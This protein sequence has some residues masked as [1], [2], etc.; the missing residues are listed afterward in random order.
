MDKLL[1]KIADVYNNYRFK[2]NKIN[3]GNYSDKDY[4][5]RAN[6]YNI[7]VFISFCL[8]GTLIGHFFEMIMLFLVFN[9][10]RDKSNGIHSYG[11]LSFCFVFSLVLFFITCFLCDF[12]FPYYIISPFSIIFTYIKSPYINEGYEQKQVEDDIKKVDYLILAI[13]F[14]ILSFAPIEDNMNNAINIAI[15][16]VSLFM[17]KKVEKLFFGIKGLLHL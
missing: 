15:I 9:V 7:I 10:L 6:L 12:N 14:W 16:S 3:S 11:S 8:F 17:S 13:L 4:T 2:H 5:F 1:I